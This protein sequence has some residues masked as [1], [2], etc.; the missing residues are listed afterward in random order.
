MTPTQSEGGWPQDAAYQPDRRTQDWIE[1]QVCNFPERWKK[2]LVNRWYSEVP[3]GRHFDATIGHHPEYFA[4]T[5]LKVWADRLGGSR[6]PLDAKDSDICDAADQLAVRCADRAKIYHDMQ[7]LRAAMNRIAEGQKIEQP[8]AWDEEKQSGV[9]DGPAVA[10]MADPLWWRRKLRRIHAKLVEGA[11]IDLGYVNRAR[12]CYVSNESVYRRAQQ[13][14]RNAATL[15]QTVMVNELGQEMKLAELAAKGP[16]NKAIRRAEL[17]TRISG[18][19]RT[20]QEMSH[21][22]LFFTMTCPSRMHK[23]ATA[24]GA[25]NRVIKNKRYDGTLPGEAQKYLAKVWS[26]IR[27]RLARQGIQPYG[28]RIA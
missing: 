13:N 23:W 1:R 17:M 11:A 20:A 9:K 24:K 21:A 16:A 12:D 19:E 25:D 22:G 8:Q 7:S 10:R 6:L 3:G 4:S 2:N 26:R 18:F 27:A 14:E 28:F 15:E 5:N